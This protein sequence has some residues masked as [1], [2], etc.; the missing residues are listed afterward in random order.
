MK[1]GSSAIQL[2]LLHEV[3][4]NNG[5]APLWQDWSIW[6]KRAVVYYL[7][8]LETVGEKHMARYQL[9]SQRKRWMCPILSKGANCQL[10]G[11]LKT[12][13]HMHTYAHI[14]IHHGKLGCAC[15]LLMRADSRDMDVSAKTK[16]AEFKF[17]SLIY[18]A[19]TACLRQHNKTVAK[20]N[21]SSSKEANKVFNI[22]K[23]SL[24]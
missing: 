16:W 22:L 1:L 2:V 10:S 13:R 11:S 8:S 23:C 18:L 19:N 15:H 12:M 4:E 5:Q 20:Q 6:K 24:R 7:S 21:T 14:T 3:C 17:T 9:L